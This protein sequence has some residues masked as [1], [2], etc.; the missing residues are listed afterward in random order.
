MSFVA[1]IV[2]SYSCRLKLSRRANKMKL[3]LLVALI[4]IGFEQVSLQQQ[5]QQEK[6]Q[7]DRYLEEQMRKL[8]SQI[9]LHFEYFKEV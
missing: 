3:L 7:R 8:Q 1:V 5:Q 4:C 9:D 2:D 6:D